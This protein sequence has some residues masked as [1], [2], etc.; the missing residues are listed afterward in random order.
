MDAIQLFAKNFI[1]T[2]YR[3]LPRDVVE[4]TKK[5]VLD[6]LGVALAGTSSPGMKDLVDIVMDWGGKAE[7]SVISRGRKVPAPMAAQA[8]ANVG[9]ALDFDDVHDLAVMH[10]AVVAVPTCMAVAESRGGVSGSEFIN[11]VALG[12]DMICRLALAAWPG[13]DPA[14]PETRGKAFQS[15]RV[16]QGWH[17]T[18]L[19]GY[20]VAAGSAGKLLD[21]DEDRMVNAFGIAYHQC[22][23]NLQGRDDGTM[24]KRLGPGFS[25][26]AGIASALMAEKGITGAKNS[27][28]GHMGLY[29]M[30]FQG[31]Y[32]RDTLTMD[33]GKHF[34]GI[35][36]SIKPYPC[37]RGIHP[38]IDAALGL[39]KAHQVKIA[40]VKQIRVFVDAGGYQMLCMPL[41]VKTKPRTPVD[42]QFSIPWGVATALTRGLVAMEHYTDV[43]MKS[44]DILET[45]SKIRVILDH[46]LDTSDKIPSGKVELE[47]TSGQV[48][49]H[50]V[51]YP[52]GSPE[53]PMTF[54]DCAGKFRNCASHSVTRVPQEQLERVIELIAQLEQIKDVGEIMRLLG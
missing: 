27:L 35:N 20:L 43:A 3:A 30:F 42:A 48:Y 51:D 12:V 33:L 54:D 41:E 44:P 22:A 38:S 37:C 28:E 26:R 53:R 19:M 21:L 18:T 6:L 24:T 5:E 15:E 10:P 39:V 31:G 29:R 4:V 49:L 1:D 8:N 47:T 7:S 13:Y 32:D 16:K 11:A 9:H 17:L 52:L 2:G 23:G 50:Q 14:V 25:A 36:V 34:E 46:S 45:A 40:D